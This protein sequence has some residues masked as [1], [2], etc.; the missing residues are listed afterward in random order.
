MDVKQDVLE[1]DRQAR[2][3]RKLRTAVFELMLSCTIIS[4][5]YL[6]IFLLVSIPVLLLTVYYLSLTDVTFDS[7]RIAILFFLSQSV[8]SKVSLE[9]LIS[10]GSIFFSFSCGKTVINVSVAY[11]TV[12][13]TFIHF[14][15]VCYC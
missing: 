5:A 7:F 15:L 1:G 10:D 14:L 12:G 9:N 3:K 6:Y 4:A 2:K 11:L 13:K 8:Q